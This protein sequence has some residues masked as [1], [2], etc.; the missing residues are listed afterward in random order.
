LHG[1]KLF[2][3]FLGLKGELYYVHD[4]EVN[5]NALAFVAHVQPDQNI[6]KYKWHTTS[7]DASIPYDIES[8]SYVHDS[9][10]L[11]VHRY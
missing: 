1:C 6:L 2:C 3:L 11:S 8:V 7:V 5:H 4:G 10:E 9:L